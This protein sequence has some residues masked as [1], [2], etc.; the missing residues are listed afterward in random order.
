[1]GISSDISLSKIN[2]SYSHSSPLHYILSHFLIRITSHYFTNPLKTCT[3]TILFI[4]RTTHLQLFVVFNVRLELK[5][6]I[7]LMDWDS[8]LIAVW[9]LSLTPLILHGKNV[10]PASVHSEVLFG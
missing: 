2:M 10:S 9:E 5:R 1:M 4:P 8:L 3:T 6:G 7:L